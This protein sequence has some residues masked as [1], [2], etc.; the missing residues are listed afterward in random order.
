MP[1]TKTIVYRGPGDVRLVRHNL[2]GELYEFNVDD[3]VECPVDLANELLE[4]KYRLWSDGKK[5]VPVE[6]AT[7]YGAQYFDEIGGEG[8]A[9]SVGG[10]G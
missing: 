6:M 5:L 3:P 8:S 4:Q 7:D 2:T 1:E 9:E 10:D